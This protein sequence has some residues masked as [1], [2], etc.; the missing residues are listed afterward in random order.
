[1][2]DDEQTLLNLLGYIYLESAQP[3][4]AAVVLAALDTL[5]PA[6]PAV[7][8]ALVLALLRS[9]KASRALTMLDELAMAGGVDAAFHL[10]R[11]QALAALERPEE[12][13]AAMQNY[14]HMRQQADALSAPLA[15]QKVP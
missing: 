11:A 14:L 7:L 13:A 15:F 5:A 2:T 6:Q 10:L 1:M 8:R 4:K 9:D 3:D 12:A